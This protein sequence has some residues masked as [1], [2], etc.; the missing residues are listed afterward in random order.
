M[1][2]VTDMSSKL[3]TDLRAVPQVE[4]AVRGSDLIVTVTPSR[5]P[6]VRAGWLE[7]GVHITA[8]GSDMPDKQELEAEVLRK[9]SWVVAD[10]I[11]QCQTSGEIH[12][13]LSQGAIRLDDIAGELGEVVI[14]R[15]PGRTS[16]DQI[17][18]C[19]LTGV[20]VQDAAAA[21]FVLHAAA[22]Q[23]L[24]MELNL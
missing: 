23:G 13:A 14:G 22:D 4:D 11:E 12:H 17:T 7:P 21:S 18:V 6:L 8:V 10:R 15:I 16:D 19:D 1:A 24:G 3:E 20:G 9:A 5:S 2:L